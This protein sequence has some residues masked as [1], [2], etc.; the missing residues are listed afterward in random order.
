MLH[1]L[2]EI[3]T[4]A[5]DGF[6]FI[7]LCELESGFLKKLLAPS[8]TFPSFV[9][10]SENKCTL[11]ITILQ[12]YFKY[13]MCKVRVLFDGRIVSFSFS[14]GSGSCKDAQEDVFGRS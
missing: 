1:V 3:R 9:P 11:T 8:R 10:I 6:V 5:E 7:R 4:F 2:V 13:A 12:M 14:Q